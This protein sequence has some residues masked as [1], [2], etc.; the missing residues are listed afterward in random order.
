MKERIVL[1]N[2]IVLLVALVGFMVIYSLL[3]GMGDNRV[4]NGTPYSNGYEATY[5]IEIIGDQRPARIQPEPL[6]DPAGARMR[7]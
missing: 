4:L 5:A 7:A 1:V 2:L 6:H 3:T